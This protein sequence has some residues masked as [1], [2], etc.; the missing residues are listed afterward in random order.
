[1]ILFQIVTSLLKQT[2]TTIFSQ[3]TPA[4]LCREQ[5][6]EIIIGGPEVQLGMRWVE[7]L[8]TLKI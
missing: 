3:L 7:M 2:I 4:T 8:T 6:R 1:M 5:K